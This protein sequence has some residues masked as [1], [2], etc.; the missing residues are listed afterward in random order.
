[1]KKKILILFTL[2]ILLISIYVVLNYIKIKN[3]KIEIV[4]KDNLTLEFND[5]KNVSSFIESINGKIINDYIIDSTKIGSKKVSFEFINDNKVKLKYNFKINV[6]DKVKPVIWLGNSYNITKGNKIELT[7]KILCGDNYDVKPNCIIDGDYN[8]NEVG[9]YPLI[10]KA[11][12]SSGNTEEKNFILNVREEIYDKKNNVETH[13][14]FED[15]VANYK[16][17]K[18]KIGIDVSSWQ[19]NIDFEK[20][21][22]AGVE[23]IIIRIGGTKGTNKEYFL[24]SKFEYN[25]KEANKYGIDVGIYFYSYANSIKGAKKDAKW[26]LKQIKDY[27]ITLPIAFDWEEWSYFNEYNLSFFG[28]TNLADSFLS[29]I[30]K[31]GYKGMLYSSKSYLDMIWLPLDYDI[32]LAHYTNKTDYEGK[33]RFWQLCDNGKIDGINSNVDIDIMYN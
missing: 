5:K 9:S 30:E 16:N 24:D 25:I 2:I 32:W 19:G 4:L 13:T 26:V 31:N 20:I 33:Y 18:T 1:M 6:V 8:I 11:T 28:L 22:K 12:D 15:V 21:K 14:N 17:N 29:V 3:S 23:F 27:K 7:K 10:F